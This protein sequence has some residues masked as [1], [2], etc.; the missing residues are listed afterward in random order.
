ML[1]RDFIHAAKATQE[2]AIHHAYV[3]WTNIR[4]KIRAQVSAF[5]K[6]SIRDILVKGSLFSTNI[7]TKIT[8]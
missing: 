7:S 5:V 1:V 8:L 6:S 4:Q 3:L 2:E